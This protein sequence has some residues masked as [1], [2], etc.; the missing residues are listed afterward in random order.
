[1]V[2]TQGAVTKGIR[3]INKHKINTGEIINFKNLVTKEKLELCWWQGRAKFS[4]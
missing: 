3:M 1:M 2:F 4:S